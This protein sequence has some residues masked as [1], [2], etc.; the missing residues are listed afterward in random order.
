MN[1]TASRTIRRPKRSIGFYLFVGL[2]LL[3]AWSLYPPSRGAATDYGYIDLT[4]P[5]LRKIPIAIPQFKT[6]NPGPEVDRLAAEG[7][8]LM[9][10]TLNFTGYFMV[11]DPAA[12][13]IDPR[14]MG[15]TQTDVD[16]K[17]WAEIGSD[18]LITG[19]M[20][21][22]E[23]VVEMELRLFD[24][25][26]QQMLVGKRYAA[27]VADLRRLV[28]RFC[29]EVLLQLTG[30]AGPFESK[31]AFISTGSGQKEVYV[32]DFDGYDPQPFT[33]HQSISLRP[34]W[35]SDGQWIS[36]MS[37]RKDR[38]ELYIRH[39]KDK[40]AAVVSKAG[41]NLNGGW[42]PGRFE[43]GATLSFSGDQEIYLLSGSGEIIKRLTN[44]PDIDVSPSFS[45]D[46]EQM[47]FVSKRAGTP[48]LYI[49][50][51][52]TGNSERLTFEGHY[53]TQP[54]WSPKGDRIA[55]TGMVKN[56]IDIFVIDLKTRQ[57]VQLTR[58]SGD[59]ESATWSPDG[60][61]IAFSSTR[62]GPSRIYVMTAFGTDQR[63]LL[64]LPGAQSMPSWSPGGIQ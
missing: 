32:C 43:L 17:A 46:G 50:D 45:P 8:R 61:L 4:N 1:Q 35:S 36:Y 9:S 33:R 30:S 11:V 54:S 60:S 20:A 14:Q 51:L 48:Q 26:K 37:Y 27:R 39:R 13:L 3:T 63:R 2:L 21:L 31:I 34:T 53:N 52:N 6:L 29:A 59:N 10:E 41:L 18:L 40:R 49:M 15:V 57:A 19:L 55:Y 23:D 22:D 38:A 42:V 62:E 25:V 12:Y 58:N 47:V 64:T 24:T 44:Q 28:R 56:Q 5:F 7:A 16:F